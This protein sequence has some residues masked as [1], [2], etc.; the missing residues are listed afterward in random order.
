MMHDRTDYRH[1]DAAQEPAARGSAKG[2]EQPPAKEGTD[3]ADD[4]ITDDTEA[5]ALDQHARQ[6][7]S[8][9]TH[10]E[11]PQQRHCTLPSS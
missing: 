9:K 2:A 3:H 10:N 5:T 7:T 6:P 4:E 11:K 8:N 1:N